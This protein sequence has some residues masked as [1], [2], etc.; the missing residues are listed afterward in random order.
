MTWTRKE[1]VERF[2]W[3]LIEARKMMTRFSKEKG[4]SYT[5][6]DEVTTEE[7][8]IATDIIKRMGYMV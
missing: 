5:K 3:L 6:L 7:V 8:E 2:E 4:I 1:T